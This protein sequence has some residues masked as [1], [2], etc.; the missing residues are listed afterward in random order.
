[1][2]LSLKELFFDKKSD[3]IILK[4]YSHLNDFIQQDIIKSELILILEN[5]N[6]DNNKSQYSLFIEKNANL[7]KEY[8]NKFKLFYLNMLDKEKLITCI[9]KNDKINDNIKKEEEEHK[10]TQNSEINFLK[11]N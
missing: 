10:N 3:K 6:L 5:K 4:L 11:D 7:N 9:S 2:Y 1:M 8:N